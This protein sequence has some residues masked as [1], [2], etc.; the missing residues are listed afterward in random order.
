M[1]NTPPCGD[2]WMIMANLESENPVANIAAMNHA[3]VLIDGGKLP[4]PQLHHASMMRLWKVRDQLTAV[5]VMYIFFH[6]SPGIINDTRCVRAFAS[7]MLSPHAAVVYAC[8][9]ALP[10]LSRV[11]PG[12]AF[13]MA[14]AYCNILIVFPPQLSFQIPSVV[15]IL[16]RLKQISTT[17]VD[18]PGLDDLAMDVLGALANR[19]FAVRRKVL[20]LA[21]SLLTPRNIVDVLWFLKNELDLAATAD[22]PIEYQQMLAA[23]I[24]ECQSAYPESIMRFILDPKYLVF[25][26]CICYIKEIMDRNPMLRPAPEGYSEG[27]PACQARGSFDAILSLFED[28]LK[29]RNMEKLIHGDTEVE[30]EYMLPR[31]YYG[32]KDKDAQGDHLKPWLMEMEELLFVHIGLTQQADGCYAIASSSEGSSSS[33]NVSLFIPSLDHTDNLEILVQSGD[34]LLADFVDDILSMLLEKDGV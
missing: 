20:N 26:D 15:L 30:Q 8:A 9:G 21:V 16:D 29:R 11:V 32:V 2:F 10:S 18:H 25:I 23:A 7:L 22:I 27:A 19:N 33:D 1:E 28:L 14:R 17:M 12:F 24:R 34:V 3:L 6:S 31:D 5:K 4:E 13:A